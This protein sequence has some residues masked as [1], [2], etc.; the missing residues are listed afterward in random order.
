MLY[1]LGLGVLEESPHLPDEPALFNDEDPPPAP[2]V[3]D[4]YGEYV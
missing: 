1:T 2:P 3:F 4:E